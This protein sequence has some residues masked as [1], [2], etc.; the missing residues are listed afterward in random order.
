M[1]TYLHKL[2]FDVRD[3]EC[4]LSGIVNNAV[5]QNYLEHARHNVLKANG[6]DYSELAARGVHLVVIRI[7]ID[8]HFPLRSG[9]RFYVGTNVERVSR[10]R[11][12]FHQD[13]L[14]LPDE[15]MILQ[16]WVIGASIDNTGRP[17]LPAD[18][19]QRF[20]QIFTRSPE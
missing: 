20:S 14:R 4:D 18:L 5:Y 12:A 6:I 13:I 8:Y 1:A 2:D 17:R 11:F 3:Y 15:R 19:E 9:D 16:A 7:E 10:L